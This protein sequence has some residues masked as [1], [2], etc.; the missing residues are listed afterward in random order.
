M[1][2]NIPVGQ[3]TK[4][5]TRQGKW[6]GSKLGKEYVKAVYCHPAYLTYMQSTSCNIPGWMN[7]ELERLQEKH[8]QPQ[9]CWWYFSNGRKQRGS[10]EPL[11]EAERGECKS[12]LKTEHS[13]N[14][15]HGI[16]SHHF[17]ANWWGNNGIGERLFFW[18]PESLQMVTIAVKLKTLTPWKES[19]DQPR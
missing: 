11:D 4:F 5:R 19:Y 3:E 6:T 17:M 18:A 10:K 14:Y 9:S 12:W 15:D 8:Q 13:K 16:Q 2:N 7:H 1:L